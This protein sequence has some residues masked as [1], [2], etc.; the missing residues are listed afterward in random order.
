MNINFKRYFLYLVRWQL[1]TPILAPVVAYFKHSPSVFGTPEDWIGSSAANL[2]GGLIFFW[3]DKFIFTSKT[4]QSQW[5][6][7]EN[8]SCVDC[9]KICRGY[10]LA[11]TGNYD[12]LN[13]KAPQ[14][15]CED[16]SQKKLDEL[17]T[18]GVRV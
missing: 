14:F 17:K 2:I 3:V 13:V 1:S 5:E 12:R 16:C 4:L 8:T 18:R 6:I 15:R 7:R 10:R 9:N 11:K